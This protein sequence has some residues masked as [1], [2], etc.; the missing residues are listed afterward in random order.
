MI[1]W[2]AYLK[3]III[4]KDYLFWSVKEQYF[5]IRFKENKHMQEHTL[6][7]G[8]WHSGR[9]LS[10]ASRSFYTLAFII[11][12]FNSKVCK[13]IQMLFSSLGGNMLKNT[14]DIIF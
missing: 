10:S 14:K 4:V 7:S 6:I 9:K 12:K 13:G 11:I 5:S 1:F 8:Q 3:Q 2:P